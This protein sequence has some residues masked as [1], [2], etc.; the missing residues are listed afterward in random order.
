[1]YFQTPTHTKWRYELNYNIS[2][3]RPWNTVQTNFD[4]SLS[5]ECRTQEIS[6]FKRPNNSTGNKINELHG[7]KSMNFSPKS[8]SIGPDIGN[9]LHQPKQRWVIQP[10]F[11]FQFDFRCHPGVLRYSCS[12]SHSIR[13]SLSPSLSEIKIHYEYQTFSLAQYSTLLEFNFSRKLKVI[14]HSIR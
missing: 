6:Q 2:Q 8:N 5:V 11:T 7:K 9:F 4:L 1:M 14:S 3:R 13:V 10:Q 12:S